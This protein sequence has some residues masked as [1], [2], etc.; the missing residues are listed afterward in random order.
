MERSFKGRRT[1]QKVPVREPKAHECI[2]ANPRVYPVGWE[3][4]AWNSVPRA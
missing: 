4:G 2:P 3:G 1:W